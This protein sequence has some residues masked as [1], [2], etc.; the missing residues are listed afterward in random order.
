MSDGVKF[1]FKTLF[2]VPIIILVA[3]FFLNIMGL[4]TTYFKVQGMQ[5]GLE[6]IVTENNY[7]SVN[8]LTKLMP[9]I[10]SLGYHNNGGTW[11]RISYVAEVGILVQNES[12]DEFRIPL[13]APDAAG[14][15]A[16]AAAIDLTD[17]VNACFADTNNSPMGKSQ[18]GR[19][20]MVGCYANYE[21]LWPLTVYDDAAT[22]VFM[23]GTVQNPAVTGY[24]SNDPSAWQNAAASQTRQTGIFTAN[25]ASGDI[26]DHA[27]TVIVPI[28]MH[29][30]VVGIKYYADMN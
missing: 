19:A 5:Y 28:G 23:D 21:V 17:N 25:N 15:N 14:T 10:W 30:T 22:G 3:Y 6:N 4:V 20:K 12:G 27:S 8:D 29:S 2:K 7:I 9:Q 24:D 1:V 26:H 11:E 13:Q 18:Y 16:N